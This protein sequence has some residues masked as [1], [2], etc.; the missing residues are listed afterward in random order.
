MAEKLG[1]YHPHPSAMTNCDYCDF[2]SLAGK[3]GRMDDYQKLLLAHMKR[4]RP[5]P[6]AVSGH[7][8]TSAAPQL[9]EGEA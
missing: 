4:P 2:Y 9:Y 8:S 6:R 1:S 7:K 3:E 5:S